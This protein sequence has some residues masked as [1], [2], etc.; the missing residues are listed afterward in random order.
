MV[1]PR[2]GA[3]RVSA[4]I[5]ATELTFFKTRL[6]TIKKRQMLYTYENCESKV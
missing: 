6:D 2:A 5:K 3:Q 1:K 4:S